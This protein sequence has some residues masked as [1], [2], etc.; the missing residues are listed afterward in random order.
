MSKQKETM[1]AMDTEPQ[2]IDEL[3]E[4][5]Q[6]LSAK[7]TLADTERAVAEF[8]LNLAKKAAMEAYETDDLEELQKKLGEWTAENLRLRAEYEASLDT[9]ENQLAAIQ[10]GPDEEE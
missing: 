6:R 2:T 8:N 7:K 5:F 4:R 9:I 1:S 10:T 3:K